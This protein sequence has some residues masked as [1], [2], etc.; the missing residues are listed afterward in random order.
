MRIELSVPLCIGSLCFLPQNDE[1]II[2]IRLLE[3]AL[4]CVTASNTALNL[5]VHVQSALGDWN[6]AQRW[7][8]LEKNVNVSEY[9]D[10]HSQYRFNRS[11]DELSPSRISRLVFLQ[12]SAKWREVKLNFTKCP[13]GTVIIHVHIR[14]LGAVPRGNWGENNLPAS[15]V[16]GI[17]LSTPSSL[18][19]PTAAEIEKK[20]T[21]FSTQ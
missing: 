20:I 14:L 15:P 17:T 1:N 2:R 3:G 12:V 19:G 6:R 9:P 5:H 13:S 16:I 10:G 11:L 18:H 21:K 8:L 7:R 4:H